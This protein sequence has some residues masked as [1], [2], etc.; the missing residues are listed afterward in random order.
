MRPE[1]ESLREDNHPNEDQMHEAFRSETMK[2]VQAA[3]DE[4]ARKKRMTLGAFAQIQFAMYAAHSADFNSHTIRRLEE[5]VR[6]FL[7]VLEDLKN[8]EDHFM[9]ALA[10]EKDDL[11]KAAP[12]PGELTGEEPKPAWEDLEKAAEAPE[13]P[14]TPSPAD[15]G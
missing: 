2:K 10:G 11:A 4:A 12:A 6:E 3:R 5:E 7:T 1:A 9:V 13:R 8:T 14:E 15:N